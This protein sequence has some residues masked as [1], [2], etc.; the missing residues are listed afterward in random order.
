MKVLL[1]NT[2]P[3]WK[4]SFP[5]EPIDLA[6]LVAT[7]TANA[8]QASF[9]K[10][11][12]GGRFS[13]LDKIAQ[14]AQAFS[15]DLV[16]F[17]TVYYNHQSAV[18]LA[19][20]LKD[21]LQCKIVFGGYYPSGHPELVLEPYA[22]YVVVGEGERTL[23]DLA[24]HLRSGDPP[25]QAIRGLA[26]NNNEHIACNPPG[27]RIRDLDAL[28]FPVRNNDM[29]YWQTGVFGKRFL[30][31]VVP[32]D[33][34]LLLG[35]RGCPYRCDFCMNQTM[36][37]GRRISRSVENIVKEILLLK[38][39]YGMKG[40]YFVDPDMFAHPTK[41]SHLFESIVTLGIAWGAQTTVRSLNET[42]ISLAARAGCKQLTIGYETGAADQMKS[43]SKRYDTD[44]AIRM[45]RLLRRQGI[46]VHGTF[47]IGFPNEDQKGV[48]ETIRFA[49]DLDPHM[50]FLG[51]LKPYKGTSYYQEAEKNG[52]LSSGDEAQKLSRIYFPVLPT[53]FI[54]R[55]RLLALLLVGYGR[56][57]LR[58]V[59][60]K[61]LFSLLRHLV[62]DAFEALRSL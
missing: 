48:C 61:G 11:I 9:I 6:Y 58:P 25:L 62:E 47:I 4:E 50:M 24:R 18:R 45:T 12:P 33:G 21:R 22:D 27:Q 55:P 52:W 34:Y 51:F 49:Q 44:Y 57:Y 30:F 1:I 36:F 19:S 8:I 13:T 40:C 5:C 29:G 28:P 37:P 15:P 20:I 59:R 3:R 2:A 32:P 14:S 16:G 46:Q 60:L 35:S 56:F 23:L 39:Q 43:L 38:S 42:N 10:Q 26:Y 53:R 41:S 54:S 7:L 17:S 31:P